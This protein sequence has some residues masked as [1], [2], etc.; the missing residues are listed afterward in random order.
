MTPF[1]WKSHVGGCRG[2]AGVLKAPLDS[3]R[4]DPR[5]LGLAG[6]LGA[7]ASRLSFGQICCRRPFFGLVAYRAGAD[8]ARLAGFSGRTPPVHGG[9]RPWPLFLPCRMGR[10]PGQ[11]HLRL[12]R[13][14]RT[15][16]FPSPVDHRGA[17]RPVRTHQESRDA[18]HERGAPP[19]VSL[20]ASPDGLPDIRMREMNVRRRFWGETALPGMSGGEAPGF[21]SL[22]MY[23]FVST[24]LCNGP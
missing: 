23:V 19:R 20:P 24:V 18:C 9:F 21:G 10:T 4:F 6:L 3:A 11:A 17:F 15:D 1:V 16:V 22:S 2:A 12:I 5:G 13:I 14:V 7:A 8:G